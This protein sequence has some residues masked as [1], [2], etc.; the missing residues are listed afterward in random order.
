MLEEQTTPNESLDL[1]R[2]AVAGGM[3][4]GVVGLGRW[5][6]MVDGCLQLRFSS[7][8]LDAAARQTISSTVELLQQRGRFK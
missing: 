6:A 4:V 8:C 7:G 1:G 5:E 2:C 3:P